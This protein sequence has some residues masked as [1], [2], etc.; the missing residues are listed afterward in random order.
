MNIFATLPS[1]QTKLKQNGYMEKKENIRLYGAG[2][3][4]QIIYSVLKRNGVM[5]SEIYDDDPSNCH[6]GYKDVLVKTR[7]TAG[8]LLNSK[9]PFIIAIGDNFYRKRIARFLKSKYAKVIHE[10]A[11]IDESVSIGNGTVI[12]AGSIVQPNTTIGEHVIINTSASIDHDN[13]IEDFAH[14]SPNATLCGSVYIGEGTHVGAG[15]VIIPE[16]KIGKW[17]I[18][19]AGSIITKDV[20]DFSTVV[21]NPGRIIKTN[22][23][24]VY[25]RKC[26]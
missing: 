18:I 14:L 12:Y 6:W 4:S 2:G 15:A 9:D 8:N 24:E 7:S 21:G 13:T 11:I 3:H 10:S 25:N 22:N 16:T 5:I 19:G 23:L 26:G 17:C 20:P 1:Y